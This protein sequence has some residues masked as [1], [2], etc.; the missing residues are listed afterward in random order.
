MHNRYHASG[1]SAAQL[2]RAYGPPRDELVRSACTN[3][4]EYHVSTLDDEIA[5]TRE[6]VKKLEGIKAILDDP[7]T[8]ELVRKHLEGERR[9]PPLP[10]YKIRRHQVGTTGA[11]KLINWFR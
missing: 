11:S 4:R 2:A 7:E 6:L 5:R 8:A 1:E 3:P 10:R 9:L